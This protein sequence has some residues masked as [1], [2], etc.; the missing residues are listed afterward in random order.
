MGRAI[1]NLVWQNMIRMMRTAKFYMVMAVTIAGLLT[2]FEGAAVYLQH[3]S[4]QIHPCELYIMS[5]NSQVTGWILY[6]GALVLLSDAPFRYPGD[7]VRILQT[8]RKTWMT[9]QLLFSG[10]LIV[11]F[12]VVLYLFFALLA[13]GHW[14]FEGG[15]SETAFQS[16][17]EGSGAI[18][19]MFAIHIPSAFLSMHPLT[20]WGI[21]LLLQWG[22]AMATVCIIMLF[23]ML[24]TPQAGLFLAAS[25]PFLDYMLVTTLDFPWSRTLA[26]VLSPYSLSMLGKLQPT[27]PGGKTVEYAVTYFGILILLLCGGLY[28]RV[29]TYDFYAVE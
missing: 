9:A 14:N 12:Q 1:W 7:T 16:V 27:I 11:V 28:M 20:A 17:R 23:R 3:S 13:V 29:R 22:M 24:G 2:C 15:W 8:S 5:L 21:S 18:G 19:I 26:Q 25:F 4:S 10:I 6:A